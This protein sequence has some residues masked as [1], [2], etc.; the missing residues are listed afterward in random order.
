[1]VVIMWL[2]SCDRL[3]STLIYFRSALKIRYGTEAVISDIILFL[4]TVEL[5]YNG[6]ACITYTWL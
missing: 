1:M 6:L 4:N 3:F 5:C 2:S